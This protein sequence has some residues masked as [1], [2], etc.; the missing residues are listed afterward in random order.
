LW[1]IILIYRKRVMVQRRSHHEIV[2]ITF[3]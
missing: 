3:L 2:Y 1:D